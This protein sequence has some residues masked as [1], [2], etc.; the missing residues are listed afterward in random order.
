[1]KLAKKP[2]IIAVLTSLIGVSG[3]TDQVDQISITELSAKTISCL[4]NQQELSERNHL[5]DYKK[6][7]RDTNTSLNASEKSDVLLQ[8]IRTYNVMHVL[9]DEI[10]LHDEMQA[11][12]SQYF[13]GRGYDLASLSEVTDH[14]RITGLSLVVHGRGANAFGGTIVIEPILFLSVAPKSRQIQIFPDAPVSAKTGDLLGYAYGYGVDE[15]QAIVLTKD[16]KRKI[17]SLDDFDDAN[18]AACK[19]AHHPIVGEVKEVLTGI[20]QQVS[21]LLNKSAPSADGASLGNAFTDMVQIA[22]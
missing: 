7:V 11:F 12:F 3:H 1:M 8:K 14:G 22:K 10:K 20:S 9:G 6:I 5:F 17:I 4:A 19:F 21:N 13:S 18:S 16:G 2:F 15:G